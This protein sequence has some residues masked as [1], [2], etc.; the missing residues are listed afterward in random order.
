VNRLADHVIGVQ[1]PIVGPERDALWID[2]FMPVQ[3]GFK[4]PRLFAQIKADR[5]GQ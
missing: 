5:S 1:Q 3:H 4:L 2:N